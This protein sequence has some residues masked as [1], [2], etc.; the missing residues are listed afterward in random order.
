VRIGV[1][2]RIR[3]GVRDKIRVRVEGKELGL[4]LRV[5]S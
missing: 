2:A 1:R 4:G 3:V 5:K